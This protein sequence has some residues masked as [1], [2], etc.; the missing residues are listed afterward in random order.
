MLY[1]RWV[2]AAD[3]ADVALACARARIAPL[4]NLTV[5]RLELQAAVLAVRM[6][7]ALRQSSRQKITAATCWT[8][9]KN[10]LAWI[11]ASDRRFHMFVANTVAEIHDITRPANWRH[12]PTRLNVADSASRG[13][14]LPELQSYQWFAGPSFLLQDENDWPVEDYVD[15]EEV[16]STDPEVKME[17]VCM[18]ALTSTTPDIRE[19]LPHIT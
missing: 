10:V 8:D 9:S 17:L 12:V 1:F 11:R 14:S 5:P 13:Q 15:V 19:A 18:A 16:L 4:K 2:N 3:R 7:K 6:L